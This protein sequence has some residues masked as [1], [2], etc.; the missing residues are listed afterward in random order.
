MFIKNGFTLTTRDGEPVKIGQTLTLQGKKFIL[1]DGAP[2]LHYNSSGHVY[3]RD[4]RL[5]EGEHTSFLYAHVFDLIW[6][7]DD[8]EEDLD[9]HLTEDP[10][11]DIF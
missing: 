8:F 6:T 10:S 3:V 1:E 5:P 9:N 4:A 7:E 11:D 2:P